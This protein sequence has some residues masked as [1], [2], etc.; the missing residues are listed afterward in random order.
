MGEDVAIHRWCLGDRHILRDYRFAEFSAKLLAQ[1]FLL[2]ARRKDAE[3]AARRALAA[4]ADAPLWTRLQLTG[5]RG[6]F[7]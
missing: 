1:A 4:R 3:P 6:D 7:S 5:M 2:G